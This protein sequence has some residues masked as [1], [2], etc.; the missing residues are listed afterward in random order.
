MRRR[1]E[2]FL[3]SLYTE[4]KDHGYIA[5]HIAFG[6]KLAGIVTKLRP[7]ADQHGFMKFL[8]NVDHADILSGFTKELAYAITDYQVWG[9]NSIA[10]PSNALDRPLY[11]RAFTR[12]QR[13]LT[14]LQV[15]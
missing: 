12:T 4:F 14:R 8:K 1:G 6:R 13:G 15:K 11:S 7:L 3:E 5:E 2:K 9:A 10:K